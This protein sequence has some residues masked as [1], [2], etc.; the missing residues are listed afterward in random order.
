MWPSLFSLL[1][2][3]SLPQLV[4]EPS[5]AVVMRTWWYLLLLW[6]VCLA[7]DAGS[8]PRVSSLPVTVQGT[9]GSLVSAA[10][11]QPMGE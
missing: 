7:A 4:L 2:R 10:A 9:A 8:L 1:L 3:I 6:T 11:L 5:L